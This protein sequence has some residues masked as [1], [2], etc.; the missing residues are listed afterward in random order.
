MGLITLSLNNVPPR[1]RGFLTKYLWEINTGVYV[2][3]VSA[4]VRIGIL[5]RCTELLNPESKLIMVYPADN[6]QGFQIETYG[7][8]Y[9]AIDF[10]GL[11]LVRKKQERTLPVRNKKIETSYV[12]LDLET[13]GL[14]VSKDHIVEMGA[15]RIE[16]SEVT[17]RFQRLIDVPVSADIAKLT[18]IEPDQIKDK[19]DIR[20]A[21]CDL[22][23]FIKGFPVVGYNIRAFDARILQAECRR[24]QVNFPLTRIIDV[25]DIVRMDRNVHSYKMYEAAR[26][27]GIAVTELHRAIPDSFICYQLYQFYVNQ[28]EG[29]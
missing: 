6:E 15:L 29:N 24:N 5:K 16:D 12:V 20:D 17:E 4:R 26:E 19:C 10:D 14:D 7:I 18:G 22:S 1:L 2:G 21:L 9:T 23:E 27:K 3:N 28:S 11:Q 8:E 25:L 13:T